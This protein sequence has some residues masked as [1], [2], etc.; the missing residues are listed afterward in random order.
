MFLKSYIVIFQNN[1]DNK[2]ILN[3]FK[4][5]IKKKIIYPSVKFNDKKNK[6]KNRIKNKIVFLMHS[7]MIKQKGVIEFIDAIKKL[8]KTDRKKSLFFL[9]GDP[10]KNNP[11]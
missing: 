11:S 5:R 4:K 3:I 10:D 7:R 6:I 2:I 9:V 8:A 1:Q